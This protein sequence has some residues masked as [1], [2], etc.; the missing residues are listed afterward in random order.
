MSNRN[1]AQN[2]QAARERLRA[3]R[4]RQAKKD[5]TRR[6]LIVGAAVVGVLAITAGVVVAVTKMN[7]GTSD[8]WKAASEKTLVKPANTTGEN[9]NEIVIGQKSAKETL[10]IFED[11]RCPMCS[12][13]EQ[14]VGSTV[15]QDMKDGRFKVR[16]VMVNFLDRQLTGDGSKNAVSALGAALNVSPDAFLDYKEALYS[17]KNHPNERDDAFADDQHLIDI[18]QQVPALKGNTKFE[19]SVKDHVYD[20]WALEMGKLFGKNGVNGTPTLLH[21]DKQLTVEGP[22]GPVPPATKELYDGVMD[23]EFG[24]RKK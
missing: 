3:E 17:K 8:H 12:D 23:K 4:E 13:F 6:Q 22:N 21:G 18:A 9:G 20:R 7:D 5:K 11:P 24:P 16:Y 19:T 15:R 14:A 2:K 1:N 10:T